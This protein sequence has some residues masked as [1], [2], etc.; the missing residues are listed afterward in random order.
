MVDELKVRKA[1]L[2]DTAAISA[3]FRA[4]IPAWQ[5][6]RL[7]G[8]VEDVPYEL[9]NIYERWLHGGAWMSIE[10]SAIFLNHLLLD[11]GIP[12]VAV[13]GRELLGYAEVYVNAEP[14]PFGTHLHINEMLVA[15]SAGDSAAVVADLLLDYIVDRANRFKC[16]AVTMPRIGDSIALQAAAR[17]GEVEAISCLRRF[18]IPARLGQV[19][20]RAAEH[21]DADPMQ[22]SGWAMPVG[23][24]TSARHQ[25]ETLWTP[26]WS[27]IPEL[28]NR[29]THR[30]KISAGGQ[31]AYT[32]VRQEMY[33]SRAADIFIW[34]A[35][36]LVPQTVTALRDWA[37][38]E[39]YRIL[40]MGVI[41]DAAKALG[42]DAEPD[43]Y[44]QETMALRVG[45]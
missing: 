12:V 15:E 31:E 9:L 25:W 42:T 13:R 35:K 11:A 30:L 23:R 14:E 33:D 24:F 7:D 20:Y 16:S 27:T 10:T 1:L 45:G 21:S 38:R 3:L 37:H 28:R 40:R 4:R 41:D 17:R 39:G 22:I 43:G 44:M 18:S 34:T 19:F 6:L 26:L 36:Q 2:D 8:Q 29:K 32:F 5:R